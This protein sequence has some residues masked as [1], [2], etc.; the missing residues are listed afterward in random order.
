MLGAALALLMAGFFFSGHAVIAVVC[1][2]LFGAA[3]AT[4]VVLTPRF[5]VPT[6]VGTPTEHLIDEMFSRRNSCTAEKRRHDM[7]KL[8]LSFTGL[9]YA[10]TEERVTEVELATGLFYFGCGRALL[11]D[12]AGPRD[13]Q[14]VH[15]DN[16]HSQIPADGSVATA[17]AAIQHAVLEAERDGRALWRGPRERPSFEGLEELLRRNGL[18]PLPELISD[19]RRGYSYSVA[20]DLLKRSE[21]PIEGFIRA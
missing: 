20:Q 13:P 15:Y 17:I 11:F 21:L 3:I 6:S 12:D 7:R 9:V 16:V 14:I 5:I 19:E 4:R 2:V 8:F 1:A 18:G 10:V